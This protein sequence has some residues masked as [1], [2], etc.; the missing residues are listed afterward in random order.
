MTR[1]VRILMLA[2]VCVALRLDP[3]TRL[4]AGPLRAGPSTRLQAGP[5][6]AGPS[7]RLQ[8]RPLRA[9]GCQKRLKDARA[10]MFTAVDRANLTIHSL[11]PSGLANVSPITRASS[12]LHP[13]S[14]PFG[15]AAMT[16]STGENLRRQGNL[17][18]LPDRRPAR[19]ACRG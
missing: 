14:G 19:D 9:G 3:S 6:R 4:Q 13:G 2:I 5:L 15:A 10:S 18:V 12:T 11:D 1:A 7:T 8:A 16:A 17:E